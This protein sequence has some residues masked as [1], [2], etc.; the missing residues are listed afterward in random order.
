MCNP[1]C[2]HHST[3]ERENS[4]KKPSCFTRMGCLDYNKKEIYLPVN[5]YKHALG[6]I[7]LRLPNPIYSFTYSILSVML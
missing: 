3:I 5:K 1:S 7:A 6:K 2:T 4:V